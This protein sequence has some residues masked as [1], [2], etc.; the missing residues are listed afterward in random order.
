MNNISETNTFIRN[1]DILKWQRSDS[2]QA[3][4]VAL[5]LELDFDACSTEQALLRDRCEREFHVLVSKAQL[6][7]ANRRIPNTKN[8]LALT[9]SFL[10]FSGVWN[11]PI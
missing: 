4:K 6:A 8:A 11:V 7:D 3:Q 5:K 2:D 9:L 10:P 1:R